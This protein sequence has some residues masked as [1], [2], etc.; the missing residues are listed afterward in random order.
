MMRLLILAALGVAAVARA[1]D[2]PPPEVLAALKVRDRMI[3]RDADVTPV[4][5]YEWETGGVQHNGWGENAKGVP[6]GAIKLTLKLFNFPTGQ[7]RKLYFG[8]GGRTP[9]HLNHDD[10]ILYSLGTSQVEVVGREVFASHPGDA[11]LHPAGVMHYSQTVAPGWRGEFAFKAQGKAGL[12]PVPLAGRDK[13]LHAVSEWVDGSV[14][15]F[16]YDAKD[17]PVTSTARVFSF[18]GYELIEAHLPRGATLPAYTPDAE[19]LLYVVSGRLKVTS[20]NESGVVG[21]GDMVRVAKGQRFARETLDDAV[22]LDVEASQTP[23]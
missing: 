6:E 18:P 8:E 3:I 22:V 9:V 10:I 11:S 15:K 20:G 1:G 16:A 5:V 14:R 23:G 2:A 17:R 4:V 19:R 12:D 7:L 13:P 21:A